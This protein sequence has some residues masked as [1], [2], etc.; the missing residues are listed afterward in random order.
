MTMKISKAIQLLQEIIAQHGDVDLAREWADGGVFIATQHLD[1]ITVVAEPI[2][3]PE[4]LKDDADLVHEILH[5]VVSPPPQ[6]TVT[7]VVCKFN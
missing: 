6:D 5:P 1:V 3:M 4:S 2:E 7:R